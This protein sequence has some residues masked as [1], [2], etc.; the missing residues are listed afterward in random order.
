MSANTEIDDC[1]S[2]VST[3][4]RDKSAQILI[5]PDGTLTSPWRQTQYLISQTS[6]YNTTTDSAF[7]NE[8]LYVYLIYDVVS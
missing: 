6:T 4:G 5:S 8:P 1:C 7:Q 2:E 3:I